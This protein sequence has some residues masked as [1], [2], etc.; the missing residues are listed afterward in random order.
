MNGW[1]CCKLIFRIVSYADN[2]YAQERSNPAPTVFI[3]ISD[4]LA[5]NKVQLNFYEM[6]PN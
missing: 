1:D 3:E 2:L 4:T 6:I 5:E